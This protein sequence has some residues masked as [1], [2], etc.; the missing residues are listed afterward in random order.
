M[1]ARYKAHTKPRVCI[2]IGNE[3]PSVFATFIWEKD[4]WHLHHHS[5]DTQAEVNRLTDALEKTNWYAERRNPAMP[6]NLAR[7]SS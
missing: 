6:D 4:M 7:C 1:V 2:E 5:S 3:I